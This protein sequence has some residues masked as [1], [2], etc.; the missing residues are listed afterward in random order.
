MF[1]DKFG[2]D[3]AHKRPGDREKEDTDKK[4][5]VITHEKWQKNSLRCEW[6]SF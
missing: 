4:I 5:I 2:T 1:Y 6:R 3:S